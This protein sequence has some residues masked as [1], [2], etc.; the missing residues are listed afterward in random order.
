MIP[1]RL[2]AAVPWWAKLAA[3]LVLSRLPLDYSVWARANLF[4]H[5]SMDRPDRALEVFSAL[6]AVA[7]AR[8]ALPEGLAV[9]E[10]GPGDSLLGS[11]AAWGFDAGRILA[12]DVGPFA[13]TTLEA[14]REL[15]RLL[16]ARGLRPLPLEGAASAEDALARMNV[17]F[18]TRGLEDLRTLPEASMD[19][20]WSTAVLE[21]I[22]LR[23]LGATLAALARV[24]K[25]EGI[26]VHGVDFSDH[27]GGALNNLRFAP[28]LWEAEWF[29]R[30]GFYTNRV[31]PSE[32]L[33]L[34]GQAGLTVEVVQRQ[35]WPAIPTPRRALHP[36]FRH[37][38]D[39]DLTSRGLLLA[40]R[41]AREA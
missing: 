29:A 34:F 7:V 35:T 15:D 26:M 38:S 40:A 10:L 24:L 11:I 25:P 16:R 5:G 33:D 21:H 12:C 41:R 6:H 8:A 39:E 9:L 32:L 20:V 4:R 28:Q 3:K 13:V 1:E 30:S 2:K 18:F 31:A 36:A 23:E 14:L 27:L 37:R 22:R 19:L 17:T